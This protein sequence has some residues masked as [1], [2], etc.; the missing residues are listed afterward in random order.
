MLQNINIVIL[1]GEEKT[2]KQHLYGN[3]IMKDSK[4]IRQI[5]VGLLAP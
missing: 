1:D 2:P 4:H 5:N 3:K